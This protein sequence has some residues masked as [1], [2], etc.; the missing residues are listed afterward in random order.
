MAGDFDGDGDDDIALVGVQAYWPSILF[1]VSD[2][3]GSFR[4]ANLPM[5]DFRLWGTQAGFALAG[6]MNADSTSD[7][8]LVGGPGW[9]TIPVARLRP[10]PY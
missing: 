5:P 4:F 8:V 3:T 1:A 10:T 7:L 9:N 6:H 2:G